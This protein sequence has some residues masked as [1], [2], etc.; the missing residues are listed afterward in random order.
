MVE[1]KQSLFTEKKILVVGDPVLGLIGVAAGAD[2]II[3]KNN[4]EELVGELK[5]IIEHYNVLIYFRSIE[6]DCRSLRDLMP[7]LKERVLTIPLDHPKEVGRVDVAEYYKSLV[8]KYL[9][10]SIEF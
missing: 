7:S 8:K 10:I 6:D 2:A 4:C 9:G 3:Y 5:R 1:V